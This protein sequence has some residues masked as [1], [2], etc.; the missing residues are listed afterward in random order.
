MAASHANPLAVLSSQVSELLQLVNG[1]RSEVSELR[2]FMDDTQPLEFLRLPDLVDELKMSKSKIC[3]WVKAGKMPKPIKVGRDTRWDRVT[4]RAWLK[5]E[6]LS[7]L[8]IGAAT[9]RASL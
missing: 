4:I 1:L 3:E 2:K 8:K 9:R 5:S 7:A 6:E